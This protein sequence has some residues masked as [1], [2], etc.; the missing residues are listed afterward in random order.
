LRPFR[1]AKCRAETGLVERYR[2]HVLLAGRFG[3]RQNGNVSRDRGLLAGRAAN[4]SINKREIAHAQPVSFM[5]WRGLG[6]GFC[7]LSERMV[8]RADGQVVG[9]GARRT[10]SRPAF[11][12]GNPGT[13]E[14][15]GE[16]RH[17]KGHHVFYIGG[18]KVMDMY[19]R[20]P[21]SLEDF[22][23]TFLRWKSVKI[24]AEQEQC[25]PKAADFQ[26]KAVRRVIVDKA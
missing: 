21:L 13:F 25:E 5:L 9:R 24:V 16:C 15:R 8:A 1:A 26:I 12:E 19:S 14:D 4:R 7:V 22:R 6:G 10:S 18:G 11:R 2:T 20:E 23:K 17:G 3:T